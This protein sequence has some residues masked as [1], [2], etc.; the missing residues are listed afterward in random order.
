MALDGIAVAAVTAELKKELLGGRIDKIYQPR[1]DEVIV[2][3]RSLGQTRWVLFSAS[4]SHPRLQLCGRPTSNPETAPMFCMTLRKH[5]AGGKIVQITQ[6]NFERIVQVHI[7]G[8]NE[9]GDMVE[10]CLTIEMMGKYSNLILIDEK[11]TVIDAIRRVSHF[12]SSVREV[13]PGKAYCF[14]P[15]QGKENPL[16][17]EKESFLKHFAEG[18]GR[19]IQSILY[20]SYTGISPVCAAE[21]CYRAGI[22]PTAHPSEVSWARLEDLYVYFRDMMDLTIGEQFQPEIAV[23][24]KTEVPAEFFAF[25]LTQYETGLKRISYTSMSALLEDFYGERDNKNYIRQKAHD[26][27]RIVVNSMDRL[28]RKEKL[29]QKALKETERMEEWRHKGEVLTSTLYLVEQGAKEAVLPDYFVGGDIR[30]SLDPQKT[31]AE[32]AQKYFAQYNKAKRTRAAL[33]QMAEQNAVEMAYLEGVLVAIDQAADESDLAEIQAELAAEG[34]MKAKTE[35]KG[36]GKKIP[37][38][39]PMHF[40]SSDGYDIFV[41]K[42]NT[43]NDVLTMKTAESTDLWFHTK[44]IPGSHVIVRTRGE[45]NPPDRTKEEAAVLAAYFS[46]AQQSGSLVA[47]DY[48]PRKFIRKPKGA[49]PGMVVYDT[50]QTAY[51]LPE[52]GVVNRLRKDKT[53]VKEDIH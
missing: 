49:K 22:D 17:M 1:K 32:N 13:L 3:V 19:N 36:R 11:G 26:M 51:V 9:M 21:L 8:M 2:S 16:Q 41:G 34:L 20:L 50:N 28:T 42:S 44:Q 47:V 24:K 48:T 33:A 27:R 5:I 35:K 23:D 53:E 14:P 18:D 45:E 10:K 38:S 29:Q 31:P 40:V 7:L 12:T 52:E 4:A 30:I 6:P 43:Q 39:Q 25:G 46:R 37:K 15:G